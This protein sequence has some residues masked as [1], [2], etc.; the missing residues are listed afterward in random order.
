M[1]LLAHLVWLAVLLVLGTLAILSI[2]S[3]VWELYVSAF[4]IAAVLYGFTWWRKR[5]Q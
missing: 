3:D 1:S 4:V 2:W 5:P